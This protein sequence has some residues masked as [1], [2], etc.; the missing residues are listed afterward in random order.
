ME[1]GLQIPYMFILLRTSHIIICK[2]KSSEEIIHL[3]TAV[4]SMYSVQCLSILYFACHIVL[5][6]F[7][8]CAYISEPRVPQNIRIFFNLIF[9]LF[10]QFTNTIGWFV[11]VYADRILK[12][13]VIGSQNLN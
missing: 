10:N 8:T 3:S 11:Q 7:E 1:S 6:A 9:H 12:L 13:E 5:D 4:I 2:T